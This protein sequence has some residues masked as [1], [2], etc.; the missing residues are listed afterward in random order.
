MLN[1]I[2]RGKAGENLVIAKLLQKGFNVF[3]TITEDNENDIIVEGLEVRH[4]YKCQIKTIDD[5]TTTKVLRISNKK[6]QYYYHFNVDV[7]IAVHEDDIYLVPKQFMMNYTSS[8]A[9]TQIEQ[10]KNNYSIFR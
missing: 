2:K 4:L 5:S 1:S 7:F 6:H 3:G 8:V 9:L 10:F